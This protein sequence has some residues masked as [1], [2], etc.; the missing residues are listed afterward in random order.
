MNLDNKESATMTRYPPG[1]KEQTRRRI[2]H[3]CR[4][5][6][7]RSGLNAGLEAMMAEVGLTKGG[8][9]THFSSKNTLLEET[10]STAFEEQKQEVVRRLDSAETDRKALV[11]ILDGYLSSDHLEDADSGCPIPR[12]L[13]DLARSDD[14]LRA[15]FN[16]YRA[17]LIAMVADRL[18]GD[19]HR[20]KELATSLVAM[21]IGAASMANAAESPGERRRILAAARRTGRRLIECSTRSAVT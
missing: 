15:P 20:R 10:L 13:S 4:Q 18:S 3:A 19:I 9:Y 7:H 6:L 12:C 16:E 1:H 5:H 2:L 14:Q 17:W 21:A 8:F 11:S